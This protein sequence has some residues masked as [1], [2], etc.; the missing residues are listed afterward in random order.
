LSVSLAYSG[1]AQQVIHSQQGTREPLFSSF[2]GEFQECRDLGVLQPV[3][4]SQQQNL[5]VRFVE[6]GKGAAHGTTLF[7]AH[8]FIGRRRAGRDESLSQVDG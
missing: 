8:R 4:D 2:G 3:K 1:F 6:L 7:T 5:A